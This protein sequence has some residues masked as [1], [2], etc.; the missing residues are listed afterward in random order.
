MVSHSKLSGGL[1]PRLT[2]S[3]P[4]SS[5]SVSLSDPG[6]DRSVMV[7]LVRSVLEGAR[8]GLSQLSVLRQIHNRTAHLRVLRNAI[9]SMG[10]P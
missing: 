10:Q 2:T 6:E 1:S 4:A 3:K 7:V 8:C 9:A 5:L